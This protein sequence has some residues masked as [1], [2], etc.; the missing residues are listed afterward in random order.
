VMKDGIIKI[1]EGANNIKR[2]I[3]NYSNLTLDNMTFY[4]E[5]QVGGEDYCLSFNNGTIIFTGN[6]SVISSTSDVVAFDVYYWANGYSNGTTVIFDDDYTGE[7]T[8]TILYDSTDSTKATLEI[9]GE[10]TFSTISL[11]SDAQGLEDPD[12][13]ITGGTYSESV[14]EYVE[15]GYELY[16]SSDGTYTYYGTEE[17]AKAAASDGDTVA[18]IKVLTSETEKYTVTLD[19]NNGTIDDYDVEILKETVLDGSE[20]P[21]P[22]ATRS[23]Y[24]FDGWKTGSKTYK[25]GSEYEVTGNITFTAQW[26]K[27]STG[28]SSYSL[29]E[30]TGSSSS[31][32]EDE[33]DNTTVTTPSTTDTTSSVFADL[34]TSHPYYDSIM[35]AYENGWMVGVSSDTFA[36]EGYLTR[37]MAAKILHNVAD[38]PEATD[39]ALF[40]DVPSGEWYSEAIA[41][42]YEQGIVVGYDSQTFGPNDYVTVNQFCIMLAK[43]KGKEVPEYT[44]NSPYA[45][46]GLIAYMIVE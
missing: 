26:T 19:A 6:T 41:W 37:A 32:D 11:S 20:Y 3:Q 17:A 23:G 12:I 16:S 42:A 43:Y 24:T 46:R 27:K 14:A 1:A 30:T 28:G 9:N 39:V 29:S 5:N 18:S 21:L 34:S 35:T 13:T 40:L 36:A 38:N 44:S 22:T 4:S 8:G 7:I 2:I 25:A 10:G 15:D 31:S 45:T 33:E